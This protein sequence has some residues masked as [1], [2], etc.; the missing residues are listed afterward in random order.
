M[1][2]IGAGEVERRL[3]YAACIP[4]MREAMIALSE[5]RTRQVLQHGRGIGADQPVDLGLGLPG[6]D[7]LHHREGDD[8]IADGIG[9]A[10]QEA[11]GCDGFP[12]RRDRQCGWLGPELPPY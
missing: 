6:Q 1:R 10:E 12:N 9:P 2:V 11:H 4:L 5:G 3:T 8:E 7:P